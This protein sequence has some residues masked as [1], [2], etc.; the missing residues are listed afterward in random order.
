MEEMDINEYLRECGR[1]ALAQR[2]LSIDDTRRP[3]LVSNSLKSGH[4]EAQ[5][6]YIMI[7]TRVHLNAK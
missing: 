4:T 7:V 6:D 1:Q 3:Q 5:H 2:M